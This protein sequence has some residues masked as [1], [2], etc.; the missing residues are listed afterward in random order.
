M[1]DTI[2]TLPLPHD[3]FAQAI[4][5][6]EP[7]LA[8]GL[9]SGHVQS[10]R[11]P[12]VGSDES[13]DDETSVLENGFGHVESVWRTRRHKGSCR[14]LGYS[15]DGTSLYSAGTDGIVKAADAQT[16]QVFGKIAVPLDA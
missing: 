9:A 1:F 10:F 14:T 6:S 2:C 15:I 5:P 13:S 7:V 11:L 16:G 12:P 3:V 4:H 8:V